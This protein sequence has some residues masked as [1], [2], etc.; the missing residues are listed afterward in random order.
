MLWPQVTVTGL[1]T[2]S[3][4]FYK[5]G[6]PTKPNGVSAVFHFKV[7]RRHACAARLC[8]HRHCEHARADLTNIEVKASTCQQCKPGVRIHMA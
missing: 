3:T 4:Y 5:V 2:G 6:D 1:T 8:C 7:L